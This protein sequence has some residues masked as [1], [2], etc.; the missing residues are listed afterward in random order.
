MR[1]TGDLHI[2][3]YLGAL[4]NWVDLQNSDEY[5][6][7]FMIADLHAMSE[8][9]DPKRLK[10]R[11]K[12]LAIDFLSCGIDPKKSTI[13]IQSH[14]IEHPYLSWIFNTLIP[15]AELKRMHQFK[16]KE[17]QYTNI[18]A[19]LFTY[20]VLQ[21]ADILMYKA[22]T[23]PVGEDQVQHVELTRV[24]AKKFNHA[25]GET[26]PKPRALLTPTP[27]VMSLTE[28]TTKMSKSKGKKNYIALSDSKDVIRKKIMSAVTDTGGDENMSPG[29]EN[30][31]TLLQ[32]F[33]HDALYNKF[34]KRFDEG[35]LHYQELKENLAEHIIET[36]APIQE[37]RTHWEQNTD[38]LAEILIDGTQ[39][40]HAIAQKTL[41]E[42]KEKTGLK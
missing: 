22:D 12:N 35:N 28:P 30:L 39:K 18:N 27:R 25:F 37:R 23:V 38:M 29:V 21:A 2:G 14:I 10:D 42:V 8:Q 7:F 20:P 13:F 11:V 32:C 24:I 26:F 6:C 17:G 9:F 4:K 40:A 41:V 5:Q 31:F 1:P 15:I 34:K 16:E 19:G 3:N 33:A 36:L